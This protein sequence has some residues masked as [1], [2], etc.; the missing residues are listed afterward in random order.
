MII[1]A[2]IDKIGL[3][4]VFGLSLLIVCFSFA[5]SEEDAPLRSLAAAFFFPLFMSIAYF[6]IPSSYELTVAYVTVACLPPLL[7]GFTWRFHDFSYHALIAVQIILVSVALWV[8]QTPQLSSWML[9]W[10]HFF[11]LGTLLVSVGAVIYMWKQNNSYWLIGSLLA[12]I[13][14]QVAL[15]VEQP[16]LYAVAV[17]LAFGLFFNFILKKLQQELTHI[18]QKADIASSQWDRTVR[19][20]VMQRTLEMERVNRQLAESVR[21][22]P[23]TGILNKNAIVEEINLAINQSRNSSFT[24]LLFDVDNFKGLNDREGHLAGDRILRQVAR[25]AL[26][27]IRTRDRVG[28]YGGDEFIILLPNTSLKDAFY[29]SKRLLER[30]ASELPCTLSLGIAV[31]PV[32][33]RNADELIN[34]ADKGLYEAKNQGKNVMAYNGCSQ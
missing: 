10:D 3:L 18:I 14:T 23:L 13:S 24:V 12:F 27:S 17:T 16:L 15:L 9:R 22:D 28:R 25:L 11:I 4:A 19:H 20:E 21:T 34:R 5:F 31:Y 26:S 1:L 6:I 33:G 7:L 32:D 30:A 2:H 29:V 8:M